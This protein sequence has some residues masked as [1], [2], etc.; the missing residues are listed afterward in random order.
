MLEPPTSSVFW[1]SPEGTLRTPALDD[2]VLES[3]TRDRM[4]KALQV[5]EP[6]LRAAIQAVADGI[7]GP[8]V[9]GAPLYG[10]LCQLLF[11]SMRGV[12]IV[13]AFEDRPPA[14]DPHLPLWKRTA[15]RLLGAE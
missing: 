6:R 8:E 14:T 15:T 12:A 10:E 13:Y 1:V 2:G 5:E 3:I 4:I 11:T 9:T 7:W